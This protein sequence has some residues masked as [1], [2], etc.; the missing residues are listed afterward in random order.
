MPR[1]A[2]LEDG[3]GPRVLAWDR[4]VGTVDSAAAT[5][6]SNTDIRLGHPAVRGEG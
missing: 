2:W 6:C 4:K 1:A 5:L 3:V